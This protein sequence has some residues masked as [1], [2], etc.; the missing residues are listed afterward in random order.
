MQVLEAGKSTIINFFIKE[1]D[2]LNYCAFVTYT[3]K[4]SLVLQNQGLP[5]TTIHKL[6]YNAYKN[7][8][9][10][11]FYFKLKPQLDRNIKLII[12]DEI[13]M[14]PMFLLKDL[15]SYKIPI[16]ALGDPGQLEPIGEDNNLL[17]HPDIFLEEIHRQAQD[18]SIIRLSMLIR[19]GKKLPFIYDDPFVKVLPRADLNIGMLLWA[20]QIL[21]A[22][23]ISRRQIN[24]ELRNYLGLFDEFPEKGDKVICLHNYWDFLNDDGFPLINGTI[25]QVTN[26]SKGVDQG[27]LGRKIL[28]DFQS[29]YSS[30]E[31]YN[32]EID[33]NIF[34]GFAPSQNIKHRKIIYEFD[35]GY[36]ITVHKAQGSQFNKVLV[37]EEHLRGN[38][39]A[40]L[41]YTAIT[42]AI[43]KL[44]FIKADKE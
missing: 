33:S 4:A 8:R 12:I 38:T 35:F 26:I 10:G 28:M 15:A 34:K 3:G 32:I 30:K 43:E 17:K 16:I 37:Y 18:N 24:Q 21:C 1:N 39:H 11:K 31:Y 23:N 29:D 27:I 5:A 44:V 6:I 36:A 7:Y 9:T 19:E 13:S 40:R 42:R 20:D 14:V 41:I 25:G 2:L 22:K